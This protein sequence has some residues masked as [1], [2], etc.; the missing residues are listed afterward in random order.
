[1]INTLEA[2]VYADGLDQVMVMIQESVVLDNSD[3]LT[4]AAIDKM[5]TTLV[6]TLPTMHE[7]DMLTM[8]KAIRDKGFRVLL[9][10]SIEVDKLLEEILPTEDLPKMAEVLQAVGAKEELSESDQLLLAELFDALEVAHNQL[11]MVCSL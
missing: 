7:A 6:M 11:A 1:M 3:K 4:E 10:R 2:K 5:K 8:V 9:P